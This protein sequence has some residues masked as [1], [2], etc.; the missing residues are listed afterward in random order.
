[1]LTPHKIYVIG[2]WKTKPA[3]R[4]EALSIAKKS[5]FE[6][7]GKV[8]V[9]V[10]PPALFLAGVQNILGARCSYAT[11][12]SYW[13]AIGSD[14]AEL[15][16]AQS[17]SVGCTY[18][19]VGHSSRR[20]LGE[21]DQDVSK[22]IHACLEN[23]LIPIVCIGESKRDTHGKYID[24]LKNQIQASFAGLS[25]QDFEHIIIAYEPLWAIGADATREAT[26]AEAEEVR[27]LIEKTIAEMTGHI[28]IGKVTII[29][30]GSVDT[31]ADVEK[32]LASGMRGVLVGRASLD[33]EKFNALVT[34][35]QNYS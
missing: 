7:D 10:A 31:P 1:M 33:S 25:K 26:P 32:Y 12:D 27:I 14:N 35:A 17:K 20:A 9:V 34:A 13:Q 4:V 28:P 11:Q 15:S 22:K 23:N 29:Y 19:I 21:T 16:P 18:A 30:G 2:N 3:T 8:E 5:T 24:A 6:K